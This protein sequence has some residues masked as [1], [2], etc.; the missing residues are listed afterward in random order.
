MTAIR[1][2]RLG[3]DKLGV[4]KTGPERFAPD[5]RFS[6]SPSEAD[7]ATASAVE[8]EI[9]EFVRRDV[10]FLRRPRTD[11]A[12]DP[13]ANNVNSLIRR[14]SGSAM[15]EID[16]V[17]LEL[18]SVRDMLRNEGDRVTREI[19]GFASLNHAAITSMKIIADS[20]GQWRNGARIEH[21]T[22]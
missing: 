17:I 5:R 15:E 13:E 11:S 20:L 4:E 2:D 18:Q 19:S 8:G 21:E 3:A 1:P 22:H 14:V 9:R 16:R 6:Q 12:G 10:S 7:L